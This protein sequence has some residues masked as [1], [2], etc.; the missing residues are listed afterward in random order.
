MC[1]DKL[2]DYTSNVELDHLL[3]PMIVWD[4][5]SDNFVSKMALVSKVEKSVDQQI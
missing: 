5:V 3:A 4:S 2:R 1:V